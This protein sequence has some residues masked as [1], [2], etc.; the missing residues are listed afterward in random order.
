MTYCRMLFL[1]LTAGL[2]SSCT[3][4][5]GGTPASQNYNCGDLT[6]GH[7]YSEA[8][9]GLRITGFRSTIT[10]ASNFYGG[11]GF[12]TN[13][14]WLSNTDGNWGWIEI[15]YMSNGVQRTKYFW[16]VL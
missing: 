5:L 15:G 16:A 12:V 3:P 10:V 13:E 6:S 7:C 1:L 8:N 11:R 14:F 4:P 2:I 9:L